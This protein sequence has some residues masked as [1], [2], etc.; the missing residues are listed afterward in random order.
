MVLDLEAH[1]KLGELR[2]FLLSEM[3]WLSQAAL[4]F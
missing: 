1:K 4:S 3:G 2:R